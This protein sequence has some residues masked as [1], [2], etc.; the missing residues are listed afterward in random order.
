MG[1]ITETTNAD[2]FSYC[3]QIVACKFMKRKY[4]NYFI[5]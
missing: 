3:S 1:C 5:L 4:F 2:V